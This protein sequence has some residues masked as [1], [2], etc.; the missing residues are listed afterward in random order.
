MD[1]NSIFASFLLIAFGYLL[2]SIP[3]AYLAGKWIKGIDL[4][5]YGSGTPSGS[6]VWEHVS[7]WALFPVAIFDIIKA[8]LPGWAGL[9]MGLGINTAIL[10]GLAALIGHNWSFFLNFTGGR[11]LTTI[12][13][14]LLVIF[15][16]GFP[17]MLA[18]LAAGY[19]LGDS[20]PWALASLITMPFLAKYLG[21][22]EKL[23]GL[24]VAMVIIVLIKRLEANGR[25]LPD[26]AEERREVILRRL[27]Y[28]RDIP[29]HIEWINRTCNDHEV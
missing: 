2:G 28:D 10:A 14:L 24:F 19:L 17:W 9:Q 7:R 25:P 12:I 29:S 16:S 8:A 4:R 18:F 23:F 3:T 1:N 27:I 26:D 21:G 20:A 6:M 22:V 11:G 13:G 5:N 15:P